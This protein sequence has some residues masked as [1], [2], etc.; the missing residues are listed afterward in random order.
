MIMNRT[1][2]PYYPS[3]YQIERVL[4]KEGATF[5]EEELRESFLSEIRPTLPGIVGPKFTPP[6]PARRLTAQQKAAI[7]PEG[8]AAVLLRQKELEKLLG[9]R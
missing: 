4:E 1:F 9:I 8:S 7:D 2:I 3:A 6:K 5:P